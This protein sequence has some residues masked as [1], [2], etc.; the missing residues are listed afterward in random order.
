L[1]SSRKYDANKNNEDD[2]KK[3]HETINSNNAEIQT[4]TKENKQLKKTVYAYQLW[5]KT[6]GG[7]N[8]NLPVANSYHRC[9]YCTKVFSTEPY[10][11]SHLI[12]RHPDHPNYLREIPV[13]LS[14]VAPP[15][16][17]V[18]NRNTINPE[19][20]EK[21]NQTLNRF[22][23]RVDQI[24]SD[25]KNDEMRTK[26]IEEFS[27]KEQTLNQTLTNQKALYDQEMQNLRKEMFSKLE[28]EKR[29]LKE[30]RE[31]ERK[32]MLE[33]EA[34][35]REAAEREAA[36]KEAAQREAEAIRKVI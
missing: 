26:L 31:L 28:E 35:R 16:V 32:E 21:L 13:T 20:F 24:E 9:K 12:R 33:R 15:P 29:V 36:Q 34:S 25:S 7:L 5:S 19:I 17:P 30:E 23:S 6:P 18:D 4:L 8:N 10:L 2:S 1:I 27:K 3:L 14:T 22:S 11:E